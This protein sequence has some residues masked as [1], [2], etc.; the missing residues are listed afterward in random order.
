MDH[1][2]KGNEILFGLFCARIFVGQIIRGDSRG[3]SQIW[4]GESILD[5]KQTKSY[6]HRKSSVS[7]IF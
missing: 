7:E 1:G 2:V 5:A 4:E 6:E 3:S